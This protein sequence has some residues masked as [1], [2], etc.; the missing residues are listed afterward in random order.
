[1]KL[2]LKLMGIG[3]AVG[4]GALLIFWLLGDIAHII[5][6]NLQ[7]SSFFLGVVLF[8]VG[9]LIIVRGTRYRYEADGGSKPSTPKKGSQDP[10]EFRKAP[11]ICM[12]AGLL[13][14]LVCA[15]TFLV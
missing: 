15:I 6:L 8:L 9:V 14:L 10:D 2:R 4:A 11:F 3:A 7:D 13:N 5:G 1:M 12:G